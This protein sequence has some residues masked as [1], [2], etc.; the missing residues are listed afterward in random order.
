MTPQGEIAPGLYAL[1]E[2]M[3]ELSRELN[4]PFNAALIAAGSDVS[5]LELVDNADY[6]SVVCETPEEAPAYD[7]WSEDK[8]GCPQPLELGLP[9]EVTARLMV[10]AY[11]EAKIQRVVARRSANN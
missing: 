8:N 1:L 6:L 10:E 7:I 9:L 4:M 2:R 3:R 11:T 5:R